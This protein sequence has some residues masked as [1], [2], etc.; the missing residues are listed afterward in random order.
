MSVKNS[1]PANR[2]KRNAAVATIT[3]TDPQCMSPEQLHL[4]QLI[5]ETADNAFRQKGIKKVTM[6]EVS[7]SIHMSKRTL[8]LFFHE[9]E[10]LVLA[11]VKNNLDREQE[12]TRQMSVRSANVLEL[13]LH[14]MEYRIKDFGSTSEYYLRE[15][16]R[17]P[18]VA[19]YFKMRRF[20]RSQEFLK[21]LKLG[22][23]QGVFIDT[24]NMDVFID[25]MALL[26][27]SVLQRDPGMDRFSVPDFVRHF[28]ITL[29]RGCATDKGR[30]IIDEFCKNNNQC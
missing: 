5:V 19:K 24:I 25:C 18:A 23:E 16:N 29:F 26:S 21:L 9:K 6:D 28:V 20:Q 8:Y 10:E 30:A 15:I 3:N 11:C 7:Q 22:V 17:Y 12:F 2:R 14:V 4:R 1:T 27:D 13:I